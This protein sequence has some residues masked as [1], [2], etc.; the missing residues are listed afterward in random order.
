M[1]HN[2]DKALPERLS[3]MNSVCFGGRMFFQE[4]YCILVLK[5]DSILIKIQVIQSLS[6]VF[7]FVTE[8]CAHT[9]NFQVFSISTASSSLFHTKQTDLTNKG[10]KPKKKK[11]K[12]SKAIK[13]PKLVKAF[14]PRKWKVCENVVSHTGKVCHYCVLSIH[15]D[16]SGASPDI[17]LD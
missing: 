13:T 14:I 17:K 4:M 6:S 1:N 16:T 8:C 15:F 11:K 3:F 5:F 2:R 10:A 7:V 12:S 9:L